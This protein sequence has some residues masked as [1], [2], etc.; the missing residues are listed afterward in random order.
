MSAINSLDLQK[1]HI[2]PLTDDCRIESFRCGE[3]EID[4][5]A[6]NK[7]KLLHTENKTKIFCAFQ[8]ENGTILGF[9]DLSFSS[10]TVP[11]MNSSDESYYRGGV[12]FIYIN[13]LAVLR[14]CQGQK[15]GTLLL[16]NA[17]RKAHTVALNVAFYGVALKSLNDRT[18]VLYK[19]H[20]FAPVDDKKHTFMILPI[21]DLYDLFNEPIAEPTHIVSPQASA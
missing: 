20:G 17:L 5:W 21:W 18:T 12:P 10:R 14:S 6:K 1:I 11:N 13:Y 8:E 9:Y 16:L 19:R 7:G 3:K 15:L 2:R 4:D